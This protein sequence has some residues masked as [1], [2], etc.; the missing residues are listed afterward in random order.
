MPLPSVKEPGDDLDGISQLD[1]TLDD[2]QQSC[3]PDAVSATEGNQ[4]ASISVP[5]ASCSSELNREIDVKDFTGAS[6][7]TVQNQGHNKGNET[8]ESMF[9]S[10][11]GD[12]PVSIQQ[13][14]ACDMMQEEPQSSTTNPHSAT[15]NNISTQHQAEAWSNHQQGI[16][17]SQ[18]SVGQEGPTLHLSHSIAGGS[19]AVPAQMQNSSSLA[20]V[21]TNSGSYLQPHIPLASHSGQLQAVPGQNLGMGFAPGYP[22]GTP[23]PNPAASQASQGT[24]VVKGKSYQRLGTIGKGGSSKVRVQDCACFQGK[25]TSFLFGRDHHFFFLAKN[26]W[27]L[28]LINHTL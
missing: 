3:K 6:H 19:D 1:C 5:T 21:F 12:K 2:S 4:K 27:A 17:A 18:M 25:K 28:N 22:P 23:F 24:I 11:T 13:W 26:V 8:G 14:N 7:I 15:L 20:T 16:Q 10:Q 9:V